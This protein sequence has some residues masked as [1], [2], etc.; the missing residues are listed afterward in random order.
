VSVV[1]GSAVALAVGLGVPAGVVLGLGLLLSL[2]LGEALELAL[3]LAEE[4]ALELAVPLGLL[5]GDV[6]GVLVVPLELAVLLGELDA[7]DFAD[8]CTEGEGQP[9]LDGLATAPVIGVPGCPA[10]E[11]AAVVGRPPAGP[12]VL[13]EEPVMTALRVEPNWANACR[14]VGTEAR[15][16]PIAK[17]AAPI[18]KAGRS[19]ASRQSTG[20]RGACRLSPRRR[21]DSSPR[22][23]SACF[24]A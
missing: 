15:T 12:E 9:D 10:T 3:A 18:A 16:K 8:E 17:T 24:V 13:V 5:V 22:R 14:D 23:R 20:R 7:D 6:A 11:G 19:I 1:E 2:E 4:L 21:V